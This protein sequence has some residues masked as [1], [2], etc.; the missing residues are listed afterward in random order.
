MTTAEARSV[1]QLP[2][3][4]CRILVADPIAEDGVERL[5]AA[6][7]VDVATGLSREELIER[8][9]GYDALVVR[10]ETRVTAELLAA[11]TRLKVVG[12]AGVGVDNIDID[13]ATR[14]GVLVLNAP[15]GNTIAA[16]EHAVALM[17]ALARNVAPADQSL[18]AGRWERSR[19][20]GMELREK[21]L[22]L[23][24]LGKIGFEVARAASQGL[25]MRVIAHDP[26]V[27]PERAE[28][29][30]V[31]LVDLDTLI[32]QS[33]VLSVHTPLNDT[34]R[35][36][37]GAEQLRA[38][39]R[40]A[41]VINVARGG[42]IDEEALAA[43]LRAGEI[44]G[45]AVDVFTKEP[46]PPDHPLLHAPG[47]LL[48]PHLGASTHEAQV[49]V[50]YDVADQIVAVLA[51]G[52]ARYAVNAPVILPEEMA[53]LQ[54]YLRLAHQM[55]ALAAQMGAG[56]VREVVCSYAGELADRDT[57]VLTAEALRGLLARF[58]ETRINPIN[59]RT[60]ARQHGIEVSES[61]SSRS[62]DYANSIVLEVVG[63]EGLS[64]AGTQLEGE[65]WITRVNGYKVRMRPSG[66]YLMG[67]NQDRP[68][69]IAGI[70]SHL[71]KHDINIAE[72]GLGRDHPRGH[73]LF[74]VEIDDPV[75]TDVLREMQLTVGLDSVREIQL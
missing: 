75:P 53:A 47:V 58:T 55:G 7:E 5:R 44:A 45:A 11:G 21:T 4:T 50:A 38:M 70:S 2:L 35:G 72:F 27:T 25:L 69:V 15:T 51:G 37:I 28:Q 67:T 41:R 42:I 68:G 17:C 62:L 59:A 63:A 8:I 71:A 12:R 14:H 52:A 18:H 73:A 32:R 40:T 30:Q 48:T 3:G 54:P 36:I 60:V 22:G 10:S 43:A 65:A 64:V 33:D 34:T 39:K 56:K 1:T 31:E 19:F 57:T 6:G 26:L 29:A 61:R 9:P 20:M 23:L 24:G 16:A 49:N 74:Y 13:A 46:P 66:R